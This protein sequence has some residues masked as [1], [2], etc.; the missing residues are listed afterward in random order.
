[1]HTLAV[2]VVMSLCP[3]VSPVSENVIDPIRPW[4]ERYQPIS[5]RLDTTRS[6]TEEEFA[7]MVARCNAVNVRIY[8]DAV[9]NHMSGAER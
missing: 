6:G 3:Q 1:M 2:N 7:S 9:I 5:Y 4:W 8:V